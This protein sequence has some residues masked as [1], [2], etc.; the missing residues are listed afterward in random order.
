MKRHWQIRRQFQAAADA[1]QRWDHASQHLLQWSHLY[2]PTDA[3]NPSI[4]LRSPSE[5]THDQCH[6]CPCINGVV[7]RMVEKKQWSLE[8]H[9]QLTA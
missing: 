9:F 1:A 3:P 7:A 8:P 5:V 2:P 4:P 6:L